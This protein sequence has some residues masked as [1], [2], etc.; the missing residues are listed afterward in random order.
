MTIIKTIQRGLLGIIALSL[1]CAIAHSAEQFL[2][3]AANNDSALVS[4]RVDP[5]SGKLTE[6]A[7]LKI[8]GSGGPM[9]VSADGQ[10]LYVDSQ[11][12]TEGEERQKPHII[13]VGIN[14]GRLKLLHVASVR[15]RSPAIHVDATGKNLLGAHYGE[16]KVS[17]WKIDAKRHC[18]G[19]V[20]DEKTTA[21]LA[22]F[23]TADPSNR[24]VYVPH[25]EP[26]AVFQFA[27]D[28]ENGKLT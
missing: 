4:Y 3:L 1:S 21:K 26:N 23:I 13:S 19:E 9:T 14:A 15:M 6:H 16:G 22:H 25:T 17:V 20:R 18:T 10:M 7:R 24:F 5:E 8:P 27:F 11:I 12:K 28:A 2:L